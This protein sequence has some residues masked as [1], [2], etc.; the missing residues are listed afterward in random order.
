MKKVMLAWKREI[1]K[2]ERRQK[3]QQKIQSSK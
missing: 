2:Q 3:E 1:V